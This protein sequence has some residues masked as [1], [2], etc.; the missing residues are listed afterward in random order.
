MKKI[1]FLFILLAVSFGY[2]QTDVLENFDGTAPTVTWF[3]DNGGATASISSTQ[4]NS[5]ANSVELITAAGGDPWQGAKLLLQDNKIDMRD[6]T[7]GVG[8]N[9]TV[10]FSLFSNSPRRFLV[11]LAD[12]DLGSTT[13]QESKTAISHTGSGWES[14]TADFTIGADLGQPGYNPPNDQF[15]SIVFFPLFNLDTAVDGWCAGCGDNSALATTTYIDDVTSFAGDAIGTVPESCSDGIMNQD[16]TGVDCGGVCSACPTPPA[17]AAPTP[18]A[19]AAGDVL[20]IYSDAYTDITIDDFDFGLC[21]G[22]PGLAVNEV[23]ISGNLTQNYLGIGCQGIDIQNN[24]I[25]ASTFT[26]LHFDFYTDETN[27][28]GKVFNI[29]LVDWAGNPTEASS[30]GLEVNF[31]DGTSPAIMTGTWVSVDVDITAIGGLVAGNLTRS[32]IAQIH[33][34]SNLANAWYDNLYL[35][36]GSPLSTD[37][38]AKNSFKTYPNPTQDNWTI[39]TSQ[40]TRISSITVFDI[41]GKSVMSIEPKDDR[42][43]IDGSEL[44][45][46]LYFAK[47][48]TAEGTSSIKL[49]KK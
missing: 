5:G 23:M 37:D 2:S 14:V 31:N 44:R 6:A 10:T 36:K 30:T 34:T 47:V 29:K 21:G 38:F 4:A 45:T 46:G 35:Y 27:L 28:V 12:G 19:R 48:E 9:K 1:T 22:T 20:S 40:G 32:D 7:T 49:V 43:V 15:S 33:I 16:E 17:T 18:P 24:R 8:T 39:E 26:N 11:K 41:L 3:D 42:V 13:A 25:D